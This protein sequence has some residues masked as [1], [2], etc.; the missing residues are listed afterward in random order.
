MRNSIVADNHAYIGNGPDITGS[1]ITYGYN[2]IQDF[3]GVT[4]VDPLTKHSTD[5]PGNTFTD[6]RIDSVLRESGGATQTHA[7]LPNSPA[8]DKIP[9]GACNI[10]GIIF[11]QRGMKR[12][13]DNEKFCDIGAYESTP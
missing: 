7:L 3:S 10:N 4:F 11:D 5:V 1:V 2:L 6:I 13:D 9:L 12:P 8:I